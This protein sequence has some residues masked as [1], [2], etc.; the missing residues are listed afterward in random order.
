MV[1]DAKNEEIKIE[2]RQAHQNPWQTRNIPLLSQHDADTS[3]SNE[4]V[5]NCKW[6]HKYV[7][8]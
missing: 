6:K 2:D 3:F 5:G 4:T 8:Y 7:T 1:S